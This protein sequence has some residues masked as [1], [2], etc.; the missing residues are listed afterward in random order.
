MAKSKL[1]AARAISIAVAVLTRYPEGKIKLMAARA[2]SIA[3]AVSIQ[4]PKGKGKIDCG[5]S[6]IN[7][8]GCFNSRPIR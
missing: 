6:N 3:V 7:C 1:I 2:I 8:S 4:D 5:E